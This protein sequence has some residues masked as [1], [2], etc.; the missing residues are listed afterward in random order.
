MYLM[1]YQYHGHIMEMHGKVQWNQWD[2]NVNISHD[3]ERN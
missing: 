3:N 1:G 2:I